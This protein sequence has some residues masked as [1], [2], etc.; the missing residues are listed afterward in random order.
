[1]SNAIVERNGYNLQPLIEER[2]SPTPDP[3]SDLNPDLDPDLHP[4]PDPNL[5]LTLTQA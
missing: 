1:M 5:D 4:D 3:E 2:I